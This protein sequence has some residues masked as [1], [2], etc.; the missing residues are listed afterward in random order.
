MIAAPLFDRIV[1]HLDPRYYPGKQFV[2]ETKNNS[3]E[4]C[5]IQ[6]A[7]LDGKPLERPWIYQ[8][9]VLDGGKLVLEL[10][11][12]QNYKWGSRPEDV[13]PQG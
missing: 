10:G 12:K 7:T 13:P 9:D 6:S 3:P 8:S 4:N 1:I 5:Y 2:I 11:P